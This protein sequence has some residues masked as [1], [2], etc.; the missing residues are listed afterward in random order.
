MGA[1]IR[2]RDW[3]STLGAPSAWSQSLRTVTGLLLT[4]HHPVCIFWGR[5]DI[6]LYND[7]YAALFGPEQHPG[8]LGLPARCVWQGIWEFVGVQLEQVKEGNGA[9]WFEDQCIPIVRHGV[10][11]ESFWSYSYSP[12]AD[13]TAPQCVGG[14]LLICQETTQRIMVQREQACRLQ[15]EAALRDRKDPADIMR[16]ATTLLGELLDA[17]RCGYG[18]VDRNGDHLIV[19]SD[20]ARDPATHLTGRIPLTD[21]G[22]SFVARHATGQIIP[23]EDPSICG[24]LRISGSMFAT[25]TDAESGMAL[26]LLRNG[27]LIAALY[28][29]RKGA[30]RWNSQ[31]EVLIAEVARRTREA[32]EHARAEG[33]REQIARALR[34]SESRYRSL[35]EAS[36]AIVWQMPASGEFSAP[37]PGWSAY[38]G[39]S[40]DQLKGW[41]WLD[42]VH[43]DDQDRM[44]EVIGQAFESRTSYESEYRLRGHDGTYRLMRTR[45]VTVLNPDGSLQGW[46]GINRDLSSQQESSDLPAEAARLMVDGDPVVTWTSTSEGQVHRFSSLWNEWTGLCASGDS[47]MQALHPE[48]HGM[49]LAALRHATSNGTPYDMEHRVRWAD[50][51]YR[52]VHAHAQPHRDAAGKILHW[53]GTMEDI[54][55]WLMNHDIHHGSELPAREVTSVRQRGLSRD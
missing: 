20:W 14:V 9:T 16:V 23:V 33:E 10:F 53:S 46:I 12:I 41:G 8:M 50:G 4:T 26:P 29:Y 6:C 52:W 37:Q 5:D 44:T 48:E 19:R 1:L 2:A 49:V 24:Q 31:Y 34:E 13:D 11:K 43:P 7:A 32:V 55:E 42:A 3:S 30:L 35:V 51:E 36:A 39:Q 28:V 17:K 45:A 38:T 22:P 18:E 40:F 15:L 54:H 25:A 27:R 47:W 21:F